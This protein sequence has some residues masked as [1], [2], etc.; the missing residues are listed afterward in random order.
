MRS[1]TTDK[2]VKAAWEL[3][4]RIEEL[5]AKIK[6]KRE[7]PILFWRGKREELA[8]LE[9]ADAADSF[10]PSDPDAAG[11]LAAH[12]K[13]RSQIE[14]LKKF[15]AEDTNHY[16]VDYS[17][18]G[19]ELNRAVGELQR[20]LWSVADPVEL[21]LAALQ[22]A[23]L[24]VGEPSATYTVAIGA[25]RFLSHSR[26]FDDGADIILRLAREVLGRKL[27]PLPEGFGVAPRPLTYAEEQFVN[28]NAAVS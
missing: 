9:A 7:Q 13:R 25:K 2:T 4:R 16:V 27:P 3:V 12:S 19:E 23:G 15:L 17:R 1:N 21:N 6:V 10:D 14:V 8:K 11:K 26:N 18:E 20:L 24:V 28:S 5:Q 22:R